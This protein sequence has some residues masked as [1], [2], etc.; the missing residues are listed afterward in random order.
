[1]LFLNIRFGSSPMYVLNTCCTNTYSIDM[2]S[3]TTLASKLI[4]KISCVRL[5][6]SISFAPKLWI[7]GI[8]ICISMLLI[9]KM[10]GVSGNGELLIS[11]IY[12]IHSSKWGTNGQ[13]RQASG[14]VR[15]GARLLLFY[16]RLNISN[17]VKQCYPAVSFSHFLLPSLLC[18]SWMLYGEE[19]RSLSLCRE[20][21]ELMIGL[22]VKC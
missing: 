16:L 13:E 4:S 2:S 14:P 8:L 15:L 12:E 19:F 9:L 5:L 6:I 18:W 21:N 20:E 17:F 3:W 22:S 1:M 11:M 10:S 7:V